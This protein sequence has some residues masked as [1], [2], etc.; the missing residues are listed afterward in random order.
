MHSIK[1]AGTI[2]I[3]FIT[4]LFAS[5]ENATII[6]PE[7]KMVPSKYVMLRN[8]A[9]QVQGKTL[10][11]DGQFLV[12]GRGI[13]GH[14][15]FIAYDDS[16]KVLMTTKSD[17]RAYRRDRGARVKAIKVTLGSVP[18]CSSVTVAFH[19]MRVKQED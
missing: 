2:I 14:F 5:G 18:S 3:L 13:Y 15:E 9:I 4:L 1:T 11:F 19:E 7:L 12:L 17:D 16:G 6:Q 8:A 10:E